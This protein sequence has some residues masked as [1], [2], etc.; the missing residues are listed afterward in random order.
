MLKLPELRGR[1]ATASAARRSPARSARRSTAYLAVRFLMRFFETR[2]LTPFAVYC[3]VA[4]IATSVY[5]AL[6]ERTGG[7]RS[8]TR[9]RRRAV[10]TMRERGWRSAGRARRG[11]RP[12]ALPDRRVA[13]QRQRPDPDPAKVHGEADDL[14]RDQVVNESHPREQRLRWPRPRSRLGSTRGPS[15]RLRSPFAVVDFDRH[16][17]EITSARAA[18]ETAIIP[19]RSRAAGAAAERQSAAHRL[20]GRLPASVPE[21]GDCDAEPDQREVAIARRRCAA[22]GWRNAVAANPA[23]SR[24]SAV[25]TYARNV[26]SFARVNR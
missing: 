11:A 1:T 26:R 22:F 9:R 4:G 16:R 8:R 12:V 18:I 21:D 15:A 25:R 14:D 19:G 23:A 6:N 7:R 17:V 5:F 3:V 13:G 24:P 20:L 2:T 10:S